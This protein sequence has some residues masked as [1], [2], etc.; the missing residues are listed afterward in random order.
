[1]SKQKRYPRKQGKVPFPKQD[2]GPKSFRALE[3][4]ANEDAK[5]IRYDKNDPSWY[6]RWPQLVKDSASLPFS[7]P[8]GELVKLN[9]RSPSDAMTVA[10]LMVINFMPSIGVA[11]TNRDP[12]NVAATNLYSFVRHENSGS[13]NYDPADLMMYVV[14]VDSLYMWHAFMRRVYGVARLY[15]PMN[16]YYPRALLAGMGMDPDDVFANL[17]Q[18]RYYINLAAAKLNTLRIPSKFTYITRHQWMCSGLYADSASAKAQTYMFVPTGAWE[19]NNTGK[20]G[21]SLNYRAW[22]TDLSDENANL[23]TVQQLNGFYEAL[24]R[25]V[26]GDE[27]VGVMSGDILKAFQDVLVAPQIAEDYFVTPVFSDEV[28][29]Q[30]HNSIAFGYH[31]QD[32]TT[33]FTKDTITQDPSVNGGAIQTNYSIVGPVNATPNMVPSDVTHLN[34]DAVINMYKDDATPDEVMVATRLMGQGQTDPDDTPVD[35]Y[36]PVYVDYAGS[37][38][39]MWYAVYQVHP[40]NPEVWLYWIFFNKMIV[41]NDPAADV[42]STAQILAAISQFDWAPKGYITSY[43]STSKVEQSL[44]F[45]FD[46]NNYT[47]VKASVIGRMHQVALLSEFQ[48]N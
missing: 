18:L 30:I 6:A 20:T 8:V 10:G 39:V 46:A 25:A 33:N 19:Y 27:D 24:F 3:E 13:R 1:M 42:F 9:P 21:T 44:G 4:A 31:Q 5:E 36:M 11:Q 16:K 17:A 23:H 14:C 12:I 28:L 29:S 45:Y 47:T 26:Q 37:E 2:R 34:V 38:L 40:S 35:G 41:N 32:G 48:Y 22:K 7:Y 15:T 43:D